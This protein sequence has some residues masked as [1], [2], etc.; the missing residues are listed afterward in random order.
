M[1]LRRANAHASRRHRRPSSEHRLSDV[2]RVRL[3][4]EIVV[5]LVL[6]RRALRH[7]TIE[8]AVAT[9]R[10]E[11]QESSGTADRRALS[12]GADAPSG[13]GQSACHDD[14]SNSVEPS[15]RLAEARGLGRAVMRTLALMPGD[16]RCLT[17][18]LVLTRLLA[19][20]RISATLVIGARSAP[21]FLA[22]AW[23]EY[24]GEALLPAG[25]DSFGRLVEL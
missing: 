12:R 17:R 23:V 11:T 5:S 2:E 21:D 3:A 16:T 15:G 8:T 9:L 24:C 6:A 25:E 22:H 1:A 20:R 13:G 10:G 4:S 14:R 18:A 7:G 19:R